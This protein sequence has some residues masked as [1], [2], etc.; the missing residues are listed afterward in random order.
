MSFKIIYADITELKADSIVNPTDSRYSGGGG[1]D[2]AIHEKCGEDL[3][4]ELSCYPPLHLGEVR[5]TESFGLPCKYIIH[6]SGPHWTGK[7]D[8]EYIVLGSCYRNAISLADHLGCKSIAFPLISSQGK[9]FPKE[10]ALTVATD[11]IKEKMEEFPDMEITLA[12]YGRWGRTVPSEIFEA[13]SE[14]IVRYYRSENEYD[15]EPLSEPGICCENVVRFL[16]N[17]LINDLIKNP[18][19]KNLDRVVLDENF[20]AMLSRLLKERNLPHSA[21]QDPI[22]MSGV[23]FWKILT[24]KS[25]PSKLTVFAIAI[26]LKLS[27]DETVEML[28]KAGYAINQSSLQDI[29][30]SSFISE[31]IYDRYKIDEALYSLDLQMLP[32]ALTDS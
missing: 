24:G 6:T 17:D 5:V 32:G 19:Q 22:G 4:E 25:N 15:E 1:V 26:E 13:V 31:G 27:L 10:A 20:G 12:V 8:L 3:E 7:S 30:V 11:A 21:V 18:T 29:V 28:M 14:N 2:R 9:G 16:D 23:G